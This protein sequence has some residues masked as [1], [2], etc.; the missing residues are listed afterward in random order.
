LSATGRPKQR[1]K[2]A[3][4]LAPDP[5]RPARR[6]RPGRPKPR[7]P[8]SRTP[9]IRTPARGAGGGPGSPPDTRPARSL[10]PWFFAVAVAVSLAGAYFLF[11]LGYGGSPG[12]GSGREVDLD[13]PA[14][15]GAEQ[16]A[17]RLAAAGLVKSAGLFAMYLRLTGGA[18]LRAG[19]HL[20]T[21]DLSPGAIVRRMQRRPVQERAKITVVEGLNRFDI[22]KRLQ[23]S[24]ICSARAFLDATTDLGLLSQLGIEGSSAEGYLFPAR[25]ELAL[26]SEASTVV[27]RMKSEFDKRFERLKRENE[28]GVEAAKRRGWSTPE[29]VTLASMVEKE[30]MADEERPIIAS[31]FINR[32]TD[33]TFTPKRLQSDPT[34]G[35]GCAA[36]PER[37]ASCRAWNGHTITPEMNADES[38]PYSTY[39][40]E[41][42]PPGPISNPGE[43]S[44]QAALA[45]A[46]TRFFYFVAR[47][48]GHHNFSETYAQHNEAIRRGRASPN[49]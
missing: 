28:A 22:A 14:G 3:S 8:S 16:A 13:W 9:R 30:A 41:G 27:T 11:V 33:A 7:A 37:I 26:D 31:V 46:D 18:D 12:P 36:M 48:E 23:N 6:A 32:L 47:G 43:R 20:L 29:I 24:K 5:S 1:A 42:L 44:L 34:S 40:H 19:R 39:R 15:L 10:K 4:S 25:Y 35:Y 17:E 49:P 45:P 38:N 2:R 21:D